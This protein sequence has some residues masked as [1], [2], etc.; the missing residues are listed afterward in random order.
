MSRKHLKQLMAAIWVSL[1]AVV[2]ADLA[3]EIALK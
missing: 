1:V 3:W 2:S